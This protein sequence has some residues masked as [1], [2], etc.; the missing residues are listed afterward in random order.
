MNE[1][2]AE[3]GPPSRWA[4][5][6][7]VAVFQGK[8]VIDGLRDLVLVPLSLAAA[9]LG[10]L[11]E[12]KD[13]GKKFYRV[14]ALGRRSERWINLFGAA[15]PSHEEEIRGEEIEQGVDDLIA[16]LEQRIVAQHDR[17]GITAQARRAV[18]GALDRLT[19]TIGKSRAR[20][21]S[22]S[23]VASDDQDSSPGSGAA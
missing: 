14:V 3:P 20:S 9:V 8:L 22:G 10:M 4:F 1:Q 18:D 5:I 12:P 16:L 23:S 6:R 17:G 19:H 21:S 7:D 15:R 13:P 2:N 11:A